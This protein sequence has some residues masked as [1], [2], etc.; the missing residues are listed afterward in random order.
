MKKILI[1]GGA[2]FIGSKLAT[3]LTS[4]SLS[5]ICVDNLSTGSVKNIEHLL[6]LENFT[7]VQESIENLQLDFETDIDWIIHLAASV[8]VD[9]ITADRLGT[10]INNSA[11][12]HRM[13]ELALLNRSKIFI[14]S[15]SEIYGVSPDIPFSETG[16]SV[17]GDTDISRWAYA[18]SKLYDEHLALGFKE[19][20]DLSVVIGR[21]FNTVGVGQSGDYGMVLPRM[22]AAAKSNRNIEVYGDGSQTRCFG[23][24]DQVIEVIYAL[25]KKENLKHNIYN[26][27]S[28]DEISIIEL[29]KMTLNLTNS[30]SKIIFRSYED[31]F[32]RNFQDMPRRVPDNQRLLN[33]IGFYPNNQIE[34]IILK[35]L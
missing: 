3:L 13:L 2:G 14:A 32:K 8:G 22:I 18:V 19:E 23:D 6:D 11:P 26:I 7:F 21:F 10:C 9:K 27:G 12:T 4:E 33:E 15:T 28:Q 1:T 29:A 31:V 35:M 5:V 24:V 34:T 20:H 25:M 16:N 30:D 17:F